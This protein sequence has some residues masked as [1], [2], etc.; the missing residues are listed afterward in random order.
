[1]T[2]STM[3]PTE[4]ITGLGRRIITAGTVEKKERA[5]KMY[6]HFAVSK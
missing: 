2:G 3:K 1:M 6:C 4:R 5:V